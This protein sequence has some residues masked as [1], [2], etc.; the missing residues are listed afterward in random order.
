MLI[1]TRSVDELLERFSSA[2]RLFVAEYAKRRVFVHAGVVAVNGRAIL[3]PG[4]TM[5]GKTTLTAELVRA[6]ATYYS[7]E[8]AVLD[9]RGRVHPFIKPLS[10]RDGGNG[11]QTDRSIEEL[12]GR[13]GTKPIP[14]GAIV[15]TEY[16][17]QSRWRPRV[18]SHGQAVLALLD[19]TVPARRDPPRILASLDQAAATATA[20]KSRR[21]EASE[22]V[23]ALLELL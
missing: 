22:T 19:N 20:I 11:R 7:D 10:M 13:T 1:R 12:G 23:G 17:E 5:S 21:G 6:G 8:Y 9:P 2:T 18:L 3:I 14:V 15:V 16:G 4:R